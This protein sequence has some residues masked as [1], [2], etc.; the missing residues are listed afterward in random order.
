MINELGVCGDASSVH[1]MGMASGRAFKSHNLSTLHVHM[2]GNSRIH[3]TASV[4]SW[5]FGLGSG[6][7]GGER[8]VLLVLLRACCRI[9]DSSAGHEEN[10][11][12][13][14]GMVV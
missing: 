2:Q 5:I 4:A 7:S 8:I 13:G 9:G 10:A 3:H 11:E 12:V 14:N 1:I 6:L